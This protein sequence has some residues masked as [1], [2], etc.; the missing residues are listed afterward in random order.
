[1]LAGGTLRGASGA[2]YLPY[3][4]RRC[5]DWLRPPLNSASFHEHDFTSSNPTTC[6]NLFKYLVTQSIIEPAAPRPRCDKLLTTLPG[7]A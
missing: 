4:N 5:G 7:L 1:M 6:R 2:P 3:M